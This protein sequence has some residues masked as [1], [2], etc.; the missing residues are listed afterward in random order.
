MEVFI[1]R[2]VKKGVR[3]ERICCFGQK[4]TE[5]GREVLISFIKALLSLLPPPL[6]RH[7]ISSAPYCPDNGIRVR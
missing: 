2:F 1:S 3:G 7:H 6:L 4:C 5:M